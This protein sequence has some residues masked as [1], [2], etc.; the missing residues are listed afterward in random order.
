[1]SFI[2]C[3][4]CE[5]RNCGHLSHV[6][7]FAPLRDS[8]VFRVRQ[9]LCP[10]CL[11]TNLEALLTPQESETLT[12][13]ACGISVEDDVWPIYVT[14]YPHKNEAQRGAMALCEEHNQE[15]RVRAAQNALELPDQ[16]VQIP[17]VVVATHLPAEAVYASLGRVDPRGKQ[18]PPSNTRSKLNDQGS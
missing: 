7:W 3:S 17:D 8:S 12:C 13:S 2:Q 16:M 18:W 11:A 1:M 5:R 6:Y 4:F 9:R 15:L 14:W 10:D